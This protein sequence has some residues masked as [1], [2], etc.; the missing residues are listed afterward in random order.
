MN[1]GPGNRQESWMPE[2]EQQVTL[3]EKT[4][5]TEVSPWKDKGTTPS[6]SLKNTP[7][8]KQLPQQDKHP[9]GNTGPNP[10]ISNGK[11]TQVG[12]GELTSSFQL[13]ASQTDRAKITPHEDDG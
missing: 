9:T 3:T 2:D 13:H 12:K 1:L 6:C 11:P 8:N 5:T 10:Q 7:V 4:E